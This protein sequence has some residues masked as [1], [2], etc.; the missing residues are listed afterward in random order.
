MEAKLAV[1]YPPT[2]PQTL[3]TI[4]QRHDSYAMTLISFWLLDYSLVCCLELS[5]ISSIVIGVK[6][7]IDCGEILSK[8]ML[9]AG[10]GSAITGA[11]LDKS[12]NQISQGAPVQKEKAITRRSRYESLAFHN[13]GLSL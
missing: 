1:S 7:M 5:F 6:Y 11:G 8:K 2:A 12:R 10:N 9:I 13:C 4:V 3:W